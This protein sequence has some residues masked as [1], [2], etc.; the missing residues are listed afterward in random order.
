MAV[1]TQQIMDAAAKLGEMLSQHPAIQ[2]YRDAQKAVSAD[3]DAARLLREFDRTLESL[4]RNEQAGVPVTD[5]QRM[6]LENLQ[7]QIMSHIKIKA[8]NMAQV[9]FVDLLRKV[10]QTIHRPLADTTG[11]GPAAGAAGGAPAGG[12]GGGAGSPR[13]VM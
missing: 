13:I 10:T 3:P 12:G 5:A 7:A 9:D 1:D 11:A 6:A 8:L 4:A 2:K